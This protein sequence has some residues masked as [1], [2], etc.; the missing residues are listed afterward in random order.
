MNGSPLHTDKKI[1]EIY[2]QYINMV[3]RIA[4]MLLKDSREAEDAAQSAFVK[5]MASNHTFQNDEHIK[6]WL[7]VTVKNECRNAL[8]H[9]WR[10]KRAY[11]GTMEEEGY[12]DENTDCDLWNAVEGLH[13]K[14]KLPLYLYYYEGYKTVEIAEMLGVNHATIRTRL[15]AAKRKLKLILEEDDIDEQRR[16]KSIL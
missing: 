12:L 3:Y 10:S 5:L 11:L 13:S 6:A 9:W 16:T 1:E 2:Y 15:L 8:A 7:I 4:R 14:Y